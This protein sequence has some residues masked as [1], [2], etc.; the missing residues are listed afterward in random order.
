MLEAK[1]G[2]SIS[3]TAS[4]FSSS[5]LLDTETDNGSQIVFVSDAG[6]LIYT[7]TIAY[8]LDKTAPSDTRIQYKNNGFKSFLNAITFG[9]FFKET[10]NVDATATDSLS[11]MDTVEYY[12]ADGEIA[13][14]STITDW[15]GSRSI[16]QNSKKIVY[17]RFTDKAGNVTICKD[18]GVVVFTDSTVSPKTST[19]DKDVLKH[20]DIAF[21]LTLNDN[22]LKAVKNGTST[23][24]NGTDYTVSGSTVTV[25]K[26]YFAQF[27][28]GDS[29]TLT[30][31]FNSMGVETDTVTL[32][33]TAI[34][35]VIDTTHIHDWAN[36]WS[37]NDTHHWHDC[38]ADSCTVSDNTYKDGYAAHNY[39]Q[40]TVQDATTLV[41]DGTC[42]DNAVYK[43]TCVCGAIGTA[44]YEKPDSKNNDKH[45]STTFTYTSIGDGKHTKKHECCGAV[46]ETVNCFGGT[47]TCTA[48]AVC[49]YCKSEF[50]DVLTHTPDR[51]APTETEPVKC[52]ECG[53]IIE[54]ATGHVHKGV[55]IPENAATAE[56]IGTKAHYKCDCGNLFSDA[57]CSM[58]ITA[59][60]L[61]IPKLAPTL[62][63]GAN[64]KAKIGSGK[65][66][67][68]HSSA[69]LADFV[70][71]S[72]DGTVIDSS[73]YT[74]TEGST[75]VT[76]K[77]DYLDTLSVNA[78]EL[79]INFNTG[80]VTT[81]FTI[82]SA[83][84]IPS[85][86][87]TGDTA[88]LMLWIAL[89]FISGMTF[90]GTTVYGR[91]K[92]SVR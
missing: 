3:K 47:A 17:V 89:L 25:K 37:K 35:S 87:Q 11:G 28:K 78:H 8:K 50:G 7:A 31:C 90:I 44:T 40:T 80:S 6:G 73:K 54:P 63:D 52:T 77:A 55:L 83:T 82:E 51:E 86:P 71:V 22:T 20:S 64:G 10:V 58:Q 57:A 12:F 18:Q 92:S 4:D 27:N 49:E 29:I 36:A 84:D 74:L 69:A 79:E 33:D 2:Y 43:Y 70:S 9:L 38:E 56:A 13:D 1:E 34:V 91:K 60:D 19:F 30:F 61:V 72:V 59:V 16:A 45:T 66:L 75:V 24:I 42:K 14:V 39:N 81:S 65:S 26:S 5:I 68:F 41:S 46:V 48:K 53:H 85:P 62:L 21:T 76:L 88:N 15:Q 23:L 67:S 32:E